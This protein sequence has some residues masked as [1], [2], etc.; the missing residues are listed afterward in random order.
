LVSIITLF[1]ISFALAFLKER[2]NLSAFKRLESIANIT[3]GRKGDASTDSRI[4]MYSD[5]WNQFLSSPL[6][7]SGIVEKNTGFYPHNVLL[8]S[9]MSTGLIGGLI[10]IVLSLFLIQKSIFLLKNYALGWSGLLAIQYY[11][12]SLFSGSLFGSS[13]MWLSMVFVFSAC[14]FYSNQRRPLI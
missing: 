8:E 10:F 2:F 9:F 4:E 13:N 14:A 12:A 7:G 5:C 11:I 6:W 1:F 3:A